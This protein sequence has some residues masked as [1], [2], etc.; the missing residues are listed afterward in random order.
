MRHRP[1]VNHLPDE[2]VV[3]VDCTRTLVRALGSAAGHV[4]TRMVQRRK[5]KR[6]E[7]RIKR[8]AN[9][10]M[11]KPNMGEAESSPEDDDTVLL[12]AE[13]GGQDSAIKMVS[14][15]FDVVGRFL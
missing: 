2:R 10:D 7:E 4:S 14:S 6:K 15:S 3:I 12:A 1:R 8:Y 13:P 11:S 5:R 9:E